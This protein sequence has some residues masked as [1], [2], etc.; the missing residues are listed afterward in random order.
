MKKAIYISAILV[1]IVFSSFSQPVIDQNDMP[2][3]G[4]TVRISTTLNVNGI[5]YTLTGQNYSWDFSSLNYIQQRVDT[6]ASVTSTPFAYQLYFNNPF[7]QTHKATIAQPQPDMDQMVNIKFTD[8]FYFFKETSASF[9]QV[10][11]GAT[12]NSLPM[13]I[14]YDNPDVWYKFP[15]TQ[16]STDSSTFSYNIQIPSLGYYGETKKRVNLVDG[17]GTIITPLDTF[18]AV[19]VLS[20]CYIHDTVYIDTLLGFGFVNDRIEK[21][22]KWL[23]DDKGIPVLKVT[24]RLDIGGSATVEYLDKYINPAGI[25]QHEN[26]IPSFSIYPNPANENASVY[27]SLNE[28]SDIKLDI[29]DLTGRNVKPIARKEFPEGYHSLPFTTRDLQ[30]GIY[31]IRISGCNFSKTFKLQVI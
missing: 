22:Y 12:L 26:A 8:V 7:D 29:F 23:A 3:I 1:V 15:L 25:I 18:Q 13:S 14:K 24:Q 21:E 31:F 10:G 6:F 11:F 27:F 5:D 28:A 4:D 2:N 16:G 30:K 17:Y 20:T 9:S 19:R